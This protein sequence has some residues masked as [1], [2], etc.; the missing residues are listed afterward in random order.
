MSLDPKYFNNPGAFFDA[1]GRDFRNPILIEQ[2][3]AILK[4][5]TCSAQALVQVLEKEPGITSKVLKTA[6]SAFFGAPRSISSLKA[7]IV[8]IGNQNIARLVLAAALTPKPSP[9]WAGFWRH[10]VAVAML[11]RHMAGFLKIYGPLEQEEF[12]T[13]GLLHDVGILIMLM[14]GEYPAVEA[15]LNSEPLTL[16]EAERR[17]FGFDHAALGKVI[18]DKWNFPSDLVNTISHHHEPDKAGDYTSRVILVHLADI[19][20]QG[21]RFGVHPREL[22]PP[23]NEVF[24]NTVLIPVEQLVI[25]GEWLVTHRAEIESFGDSIALAD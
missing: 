19:I 14:S 1:F 25:F 8:R 22:P 11:S 13:M 5:P 17:V 23:T 24:L 7:A 2:S 21:F 6:N 10:S 20:A 9:L 16:D 3:L 15:Q 4:D 12:F 18:A